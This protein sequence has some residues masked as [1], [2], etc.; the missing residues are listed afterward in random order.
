MK[1]ICS[2]T[3]I[4]AVAGVTFVGSTGWA[5]AEADRAAV[6]VPEDKIKEIDI[7]DRKGVDGL[8]SVN[9]NVNL[10]Q[11]DS[12][13]GQVDGFSLLFGLGIKGGIDWING[14]HEFRN[15]LTIDES[16]ARTPVLDEFVKNNDEIALEALYNYFFLDWAGA[17]ARLQ[18]TSALL[19]TEDVRAEPVT[20]VIARNDGTTDTIADTT[21]VELADSFE[22]FSMYQSGGLFAEPLQKDAIS[23][24][25]RTGIGARETFAD[26][27][28]V[29][30]DDDATPEIEAKE[31]SNV[32]QGGAEAFLGFSGNA[33]ENRL[34]YEAGASVLVPF[35]NNDDQG[36]SAGELTRYAVTAA[37]NFSVFSWMGL[38]YKLKVISDPQL[39]EEVQ[40]QNNLLLSFSYT[41]VERSDPPPAPTPDPA[42]E[43]LKEAEAQAEEA[44]KRAEEAEARAAE[45]E[46][47]AA[48]AEAAAQEAAE[49]AA[50]PADDGAGTDGTDGTDDGAGTD[51]TD[52]TDG[53]GGTDDGAGTDGAN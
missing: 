12:V 18:F 34:S 39:L 28:L 42:E 30:D 44:K 35:L 9:G 29:L 6:Y 21:R 52:G 53:T 2:W 20:F 23:I 45:A 10:V 24:S 46:K 27:V 25:I 31:L 40:I 1:R 43:K 4:L 19:P 33:Y 26:G 13:V 38:S 48:E 5:Q 51:G 32:F 50:E 16:W 36:R 7:E 49:P 8:L 37:A 22:P 41:F 15:T 17:F 11:N 3:K 14:R 47:R